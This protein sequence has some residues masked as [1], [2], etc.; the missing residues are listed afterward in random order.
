MGSP[1]MERSLSTGFLPTRDCFYDRVENV[2]VT[3]IVFPKELYHKIFSQHCGSWQKKLYMSLYEDKCKIAPLGENHLSYSFR[4]TIHKSD[5]SSESPGELV[6]DT[7]PQE[8]FQGFRVCLS[9]GPGLYFY[10]K[11]LGDFHD[12]SSL[13]T[14]FQKETYEVL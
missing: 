14:M 1:R 12:G 3:N 13:R 4:I 5:S 9:L 2:T 8:P 11:L 6:K 7:A 10:N